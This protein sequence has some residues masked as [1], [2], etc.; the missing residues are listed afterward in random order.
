MIILQKFL[1]L[2]NT[3]K[4]IPLKGQVTYEHFREV[5]MFDILTGSNGSYGSNS[6]NITSHL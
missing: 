5:P 6:T 4:I 1:F 3:D 2:N